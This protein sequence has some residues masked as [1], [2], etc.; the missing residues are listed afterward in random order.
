MPF[1]DIL[2]QERAKRILGRA[3]AENKLPHAYL[4]YGAEGLGRF[5]TA[6]TLAQAL[7]CEQGGGDACGACSACTRVGREGHP[8]VIAVRP[9]SRAGTKEWV[10]D[11]KLGTIRIEQVREFQRWIAVRAF[12]GGW[13][14]GIF[15][16]ADRM[17]QA[18]SNA[19]LKTLEEPPPASLLILISPTRSRLLPTIVSRCQPVHFVPLPR[20]TLETFLAKRGDSP[21]ELLPLVSALS[22]GRPG[23]AVQM[24]LEWVSGVRREWIDRLQ[25]FL[26]SGWG[27][28]LVSFAEDLSRSDR[29][30]DVLD[31]FEGW[32]RDVLVCRVSGPERVMNRDYMEEIS[33]AARE[34]DP[35]GTISRIDSIRRARR[36]ILGAY[37]LNKQMVMECLLLTLSGSDA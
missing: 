11:L 9:E 36:E 26:I 18:A 1:A 16:G 22:G 30:L 15:E 20:E 10:V 21:K 37:N 33:A 14:V 34:Q 4:F 24:D 5:K 17:N 3:L 12:E 23:K 19:L 35:M 31:L 29:L 13:K 8:D 6:L 7:M 25:S 27:G 32:Y 2:G 28:G